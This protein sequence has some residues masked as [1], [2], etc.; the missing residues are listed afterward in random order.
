[1]LPTFPELVK[2]VEEIAVEFGFPAEL[3]VE[4]VRVAIGQG[5]RPE[6]VFP[7]GVI[8]SNRRVLQVRR[9]SDFHLNQAGRRLP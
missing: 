3:R 9:E 5:V 8:E 4:A 2:Q 1:M 7:A 6:V